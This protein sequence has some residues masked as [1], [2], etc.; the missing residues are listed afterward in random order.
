MVVEVGQVLMVMGLLVFLPLVLVVGAVVRPM[1]LLVEMEDLELLRVDPFVGFG[2]PVGIIQSF[3]GKGA[4][5]QAIRE[6][7]TELYRQVA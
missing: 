7:E 4:Y 6:L 1:M 2:T 3:G 5:I